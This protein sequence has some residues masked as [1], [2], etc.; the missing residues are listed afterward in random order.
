MGQQH[1]VRRTARAIFV[2]LAGALLGGCGGG[3]EIDRS[4]QQDNRQQVAQVPPQVPAP[5]KPDVETLLDWAEQAYPHLFP[6]HET[7]RSSPPYLYRHYP[8]TGNYV[9]VAGETVAVLGPVSNGVVLDVGTLF[10]FRCQVYPTDCAPPVIATHPRDTTTVT[11]TGARFGIELIAGSVA[12]Y[13]WQRS[14]DGGAS[15]ADI[16]G[17]V[18]AAYVAPSLDLSSSGHQF[19]VRVIN[20]AGETVSQAARLTV[21][22]PAPTLAVPPLA[23]SATVGSGF[24]FSVQ[25]AGTPPFSYQ[26][27]R[28][29]APIAGATANTLA[30][31]AAGY[32]DDG[33]A[34]GVRVANGGGAVTSAPAVLTVVSAQAPVPVSACREITTAGS[35]VLTKDL[36]AT[37]G[38][39]VSIHDVDGVQL[40]CAGH[41]LRGNRV[42]LS[43]ALRISRVRNFSVKNCAL[44]IQWIDI[45]D[46]SRGSL[47]GLQVSPL[48][49]KFASVIN[50]V[51]TSALVFANNMISSGTY[52]QRYGT[53][54]AVY[55]NRITAPAGTG[56][57]IVPGNIV[58]TWGR[59]NHF[60]ANVL[61]GSWN[62][63]PGPWNGADDGFVLQ[64]E[65]GAVIEHNTMS[66]FFD[67]G[68]E[69]V[70]K[71]AGAT[72]RHNRI[73]DT[74][75]CGIGGWYWSSVVDSTIADNTV[76]RSPSLFLIYRSYGLRAAGSD[77]KDLLPADTAVEFR[78]N[79]FEGN[80]FI[81]PLVTAG[82]SA[83]MPLFNRLGYGGGISS[84]PGERAA[85][86][87]DFII[88]RNLFRNNDFGQTLF[89]PDFGPN[90]VPGV[91]IDGG[92]NRC[93]TLLTTDYPLKCD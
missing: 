36:D 49:A 67:C 92:G 3:G 71:L 84:L 78:D 16:T 85:Q 56:S 31:P 25:A 40:D 22:P 13:Q 75:I 80:R 79:V 38:A 88:T 19:R 55:A 33:V 51:G 11:G 52:Q 64:D 53:G 12:A 37:D 6:R 63:V 86:P 76:Q 54:N 83:Y 58:S 89:A 2:A 35:Y 42:N 50:A 81:E 77:D 34:Y 61:E 60:S 65:T 73:V 70:G 74:G 20:S 14:T 18:G 29:G 91:V 45:E 48:D 1:F 44:T 72:I 82:F 57:S 21:N 90:P 30:I 23:G 24:V 69:W 26:W 93:K 43:T 9:G 39:C 7:T 17:A 68:I 87:A 66:G 32:G 10:D 5:R 15:F 8:D 28:A 59:N 47:T 27:Y 4:T 41:A 62:R 46:A